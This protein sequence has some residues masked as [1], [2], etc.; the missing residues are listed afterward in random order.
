MRCLIS[1]VMMLGLLANTIANPVTKQLQET[2]DSGAD[3]V[4]E[5]GK[6]YGIDETL[7]LKTKGQRIYTDN[8]KSI[9]DYAILRVVNPEMITIINAEGLANIIIENVHIDGNRD[10]MRPSA[11]QIPM[12]PFISLGKIGG[13]DQ[14]IK[15]CIITNA[16]NSGG[17]AAIHV[18]EYAFR[19]IIQDNIIFGSGTDV[20]GNGRSALEYP[21]GW[22]DGISVA[23]CNSLIKNN[24]IIDATDEGIMVQGAT[25]TKVL[26]NVTVA[27]SREALAGV[28][29]ID[30][31]HYCLLDSIENTFDYRGVEVK[32]NL[33]DALGARVHIGFPCGADV[34]NFN[35]QKRVI[36]GAEVTENE[37]IGKVGGYGFAVGGVKDFNV[38]NNKVKAVFEERGDGLPNNP[39]DEATA[40][41]Y[42][43][44]ITTNCKLQKEFKPAQK[45]IIHL[46]RNF[47]TPVNEAGYR[48][49]DKYG[50]IEVEAIVSAAYMEMLSR[51]PSK[52]EA[53]SWQK[54]LHETRSNADAVR[55]ALMISPEFQTRNQSWRVTQLQEC[56]VQLFMQQ[57]Y[58][59]FDTIGKESWP[60]AHELHKVLFDKY[61]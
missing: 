7:K 12:Q 48:I 44:S 19:T 37:M 22:G 27:L 56:R 3:L 30:P 26:N 20:L 61:D 18:H 55:T 2:L 32:N 23:A 36:V 28:A 33:V 24:L 13:D 50:E 10:N 54:W 29:L 31:A 8:V 9:R 49:L 11:G 53:L 21:F 45:H 51:F 40:F 6:I 58:H 39:P 5:K 35:Q 38:T 16:R 25:G 1:I 34:W 43:A 60:S 4:L 14:I 52:T 15:N 42:D 46:M 41:I 47:R 59:A 17:W 57:L